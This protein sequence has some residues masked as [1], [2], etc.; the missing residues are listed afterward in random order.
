[1]IAS[2]GGVVMIACGIMLAD[3][4]GRRCGAPKGLVRSA[5]GLQ[6]VEVAV[7]VLR[8][9]GCER[10]LALTGVRSSEA[11]VL[12]P[13]GARVVE[14]LGVDPWCGPAQAVWRDPRPALHDHLRQRRQPTSH[15]LAHSQ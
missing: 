15:R 5:D 13:A 6:R 10:V 11:A 4:A 1:M 2:V 14:A 7:G 9:G 8:A 3:G 12:V